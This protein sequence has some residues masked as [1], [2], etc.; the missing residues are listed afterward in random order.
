VP[1][2]HNLASPQTGLRE[3]FIALDRASAQAA[4]VAQQQ[5]NYYADLDTFFKAW[6]SVAPSLEAATEGG[7]ASLRQATYSLPHQAP[8]IEAATEFMHLLRPSTKALRTVA[9]QLA[10][11]F[12]AGARN[13]TPAKELNVRLAESS[14]ALAEFAENPVAALGIEDFAQTLEIG[15][16]LLAGIT[17]LQSYCNYIAL[18]F[19]NL[20]SL[21]SENI[22]VGTLSR[23]GFVLAP[24][25]PN[26]EGYPASEPANGPSTEPLELGSKAI[27][28]NDH[29]HVN[30][31]P[32]VAGPGQPKVCEAGNETYV[33]HQAVIG[34][35]PATDVSAG[36][37]RTVR[38]E[39]LYGETYPASVLRALGIGT[40]KAGG[41]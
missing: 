4:P 8:F 19:R 24:T 32:N 30:P 10:A 13:L 17:P 35:A 29:V 5:A 21:D 3:F 16:P 9:P 1:V 18:T 14:K 40:G 22:G 15:N 2:L 20:A 38:K 7:P 12:T 36:R 25:G 28:D 39:D 41:R 31:Y 33:E 11:A 27:L 26:N 34:N 6:A 23:A 37:E